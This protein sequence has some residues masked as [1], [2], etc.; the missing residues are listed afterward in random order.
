MKGY[1]GKKTIKTFE[2]ENENQN[3]RHNLKNGRVTNE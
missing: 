1:H 2:N 3:V